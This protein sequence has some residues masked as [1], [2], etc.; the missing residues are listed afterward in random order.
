MSPLYWTSEQV[1]YR[2][3]ANR[4]RSSALARQRRPWP[5]RV[6]SRLGVVPRGIILAA[7]AYVILALVLSL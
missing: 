7:V 2:R 3:L 6:W 5:R 4:V 1:E